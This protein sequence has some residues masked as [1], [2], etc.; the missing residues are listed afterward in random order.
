MAGSDSL[1]RDLIMVYDVSNYIANDCKLFSKQISDFQ[2]TRLKYVDS[3]NPNL[4]VSCGRENICFWNMKNKF[5][6]IVPLEL[7]EHAQNNIFTDVDVLAQKVI[8]C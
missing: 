7:N 2:I 6:T 1:N 3:K 4:L 8:V 5:L